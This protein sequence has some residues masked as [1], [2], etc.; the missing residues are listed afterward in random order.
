L[1]KLNDFV[2]AVFSIGF[3]LGPDH[4]FVDSLD[5]EDFDLGCES[6]GRFA[7][8]FDVGESSCQRLFKSQGWTSVS[9][10][11]AVFNVDFTHLF[12]LIKYY[13]K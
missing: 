3:S 11:A 4:F 13:K 9:S 5:P 7:V 6:I 10:S 8:D 1:E 2:V 12:S